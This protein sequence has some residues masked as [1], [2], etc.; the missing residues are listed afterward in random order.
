MSRWVSGT[1]W[2]VL[3]AACSQLALGMIYWDKGWLGIGCTV[4]AGLMFVRFVVNL[5]VWR[6]RYRAMRTLTPAERAWAQRVA[7]TLCM[8]V[9]LTGCETQARVIRQQTEYDTAQLVHASDCEVVTAFDDRGVRCYVLRQ[10]C[11]RTEVRMDC[12][13]I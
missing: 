8:A 2:D 10:T 11:V 12:V 4:A 6:R 9:L 13:R 7:G 1:N 3:S 5:I